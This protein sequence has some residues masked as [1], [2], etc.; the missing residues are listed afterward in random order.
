MKTSTTLTILLL[1]AN[2]AEASWGRRGGFDGFGHYPTFHPAWDDSHRHFRYPEQHYGLARNPHYQRHVS[3]QIPKMP[4]TVRPPPTPPPPPAESNAYD[5]FTAAFLNYAGED[6]VLSAVELGHLVHAATGEIT[7]PSRHSVLQIMQQWDSNYD[8]SLNLS[9]F[10]KMYGELQRQ[11]PSAFQQ[12]WDNLRSSKGKMVAGKASKSKDSRSPDHDLRSATQT[13][14]DP[15]YVPELS[16]RS[17]G[18]STH[19]TA[20]KTRVSSTGTRVP[21]PRKGRLNYIENGKRFFELV[22]DDDDQENGDGPLTVQTIVSTRVVGEV[23]S[24]AESDVW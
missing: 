8:G 1:G 16:A 3:P 19:T 11:M 23:D 7:P 4:P 12:H 22:F 20:K 21:Q 6:V 13:T 10:M 2:A 24:W 14:E 18:V 9:E 17:P 15:K 5:D